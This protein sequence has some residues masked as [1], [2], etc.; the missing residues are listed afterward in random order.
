MTAAAYTR[1]EVAGMVADLLDDARYPRTVASI[2]DELDL[3]WH[4]VKDAIDHLD[5]GGKVERTW[6]HI[7]DHGLEAGYGFQYAIRQH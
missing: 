4:T 2:A 7:S 1:E 5:R 6:G 3:T